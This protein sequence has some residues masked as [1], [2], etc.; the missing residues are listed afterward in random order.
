MTINEARHKLHDGTFL[1]GGF[2]RR[3]AIRE[4]SASSDPASVTVLAEALGKGHPDTARIDA[5]LRQ[6]SAERDALKVL[7]LWEH[8]AQTPTTTVA[9]ILAHLGWLA[10]QVARAGTVRGILAAATQDAAPEI[11]TAITVFA[12][13]LPVADGEINDVLCG[14]WV[15]S[16]STDLGQ[17]IIEQG[18]QP[19][20][21]ASVAALAE[22][23]DKSHRD[24]ARIGAVLRQLSAEHDTGKVLALWEYWALVPTA[25][26]AA[27]LAHLG[28]LSGC[29]QPKT[30]ATSSLLQILWRIT[31]PPEILKAVTIFTR[32]PSQTSITISWC[33]DVPNRKIWN[34]SLPNRKGSPAILHWKRCMRWL[35]AGRNAMPHCTTKAAIC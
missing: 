8:W 30:T 31:V 2:R 11:L 13:S 27:I 18:R 19:G 4:L 17:L 20:S 21:P 6:L 28:W 25:P 10:G 35:R 34:N 24:A 22:A 3:F 15:R 9:S 12:R 29:T 16:Q 26:I 7:A 5:A 23:L 32:L 1:L 33:M 14:A